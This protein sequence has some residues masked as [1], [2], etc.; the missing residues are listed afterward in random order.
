MQ[1]FHFVIQH[2]SGQMNKGA[3]ALSRRYLLLSTLESKALG[4][5][6]IKNMYAQDEDLKAIVESCSSYAHGSFHLE[7]GFLFEGNRLCAPKCCFEELL[8]RELHRRALADHF[9]IEKTCPML[10]EHYFWPKISRDVEHF[11][12]K[13]LHLP[14]C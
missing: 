12:K 11:T 13:V 8:I 4:F 9:G 1:A 10:K 3:N 14:I 7:N 2:K 6:C 5:E